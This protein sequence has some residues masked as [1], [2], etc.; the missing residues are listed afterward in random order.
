MRTIGLYFD[1]TT[2]PAQLLATIER[3]FRQVRR[4][5][6]RS[7]LLGP[8]MK[9][10]KI[11]IS[12]LEFHEPDELLVLDDSFPNGVSTLAFDEYRPAWDEHKRVSRVLINYLA[13]L[14]PNMLVE[15]SESYPWFALPYPQYLAWRLA[16]QWGGS[17]QRALKVLEAVRKRTS[18][19]APP[20]PEEFWYAVASND[21]ETIGSA[22]EHDVDTDYRVKGWD[23]QHLHTAAELGFYDALRLLLRSGMDPNARDS[24]GSTPLHLAVHSATHEFE[25]RGKANLSSIRELCLAGANIDA[26]DSSGRS[27]ADIAANSGIIWPART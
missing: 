6:S 21:L 4:G 16:T 22:L 11:W 1:A 27:A 3:E 18:L 13:H 19:S 8:S 17:S 10:S 5:S 15:D 20:A 12:E 23:G 26:R 9:E 14:H 25:L 7:L 24:N 2:C